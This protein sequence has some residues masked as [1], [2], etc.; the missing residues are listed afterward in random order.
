MIIVFGVFWCHVNIVV[1]DIG[2]GVVGVD[3]VAGVVD[4]VH[5]WS[6]GVKSG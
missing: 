4:I 1:D 6:F 3:G 5:K 2:V